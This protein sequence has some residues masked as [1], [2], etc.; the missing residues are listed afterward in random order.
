MFEHYVVQERYCN[1]CSFAGSASKAR[2]ASSRHL[3]HSLIWIDVCSF[4]DRG[5]LP[6][7]KLAHLL[8]PFLLVESFQQLDPLLV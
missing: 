1:L 7:E 6:F 8:E 2:S 4:P 5:E 3:S